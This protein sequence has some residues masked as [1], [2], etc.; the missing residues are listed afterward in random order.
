MGAEARG[1]AP[2]SAAMRDMTPP[3]GG[4]LALTPE[5]SYETGWEWAEW[6]GHVVMDGQCFLRK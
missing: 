3:A 1:D 5:Y 6:G 4:A 2:E